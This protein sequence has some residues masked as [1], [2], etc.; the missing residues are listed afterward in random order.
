[1]LARRQRLGLALREIGLHPL[2][3]S[4]SGAKAPYG[5]AIA[6]GVY[7]SMILPSVIG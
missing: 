1:M 4:R 3:L 7:L 6:S 5:V 2:R